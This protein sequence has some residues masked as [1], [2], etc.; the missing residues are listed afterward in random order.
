M[1]YSRILESARLP[2]RSLD[3]NPQP[4]CPCVVLA[5]TS[6]SMSG[7]PIT[8]L[9]EGIRTFEEELKKDTLASLRVEPLVVSFDDRVVAH[10]N[11]VTADDFLAP[12]LRVGGSTQMAEGLLKAL[13]L[14]EERKEAYK[15]S[16]LAYFRPWILL[17]TD[18]EPTDSDER[19]Q[20]A[21][22]AIGEAERDKKVSLFAVGVQG[23]NMQKLAQVSSRTPLH[24]RGL[25]F[26]E[27]FCW[28]SSSLGAVS[29]SRPGDAVALQPVDGWAEI[30]A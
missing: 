10:G 12:T 28:L 18:G 23:A 29:R 14:V 11:F 27:L 21:C 1:S 3:D 25:N 6:G 8:Q 2:E 9:N 15:R 13:S 4:R 7:A 30:G 19:F 26:Q 20:Q 24:L 16:G 17:I 22:R 5:D